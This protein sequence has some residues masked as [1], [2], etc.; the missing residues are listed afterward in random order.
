MLAGDGPKRGHR[1]ASRT[2]A[3]PSSS[4]GSMPSMSN[5]ERDPVE[6]VCPPQELSGP[7]VQVLAARDVPLGGPRAMNVRRTLPQ[8]GR[9]TIGAWCFADHYGPDDVATSGGMVV[10]NRSRYPPPYRRS[11]S[12]TVGIGQ[13]SIKVSIRAIACSWLAVVRWR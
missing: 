12:A 1:S 10:P 4:A 8:R 5:L 6:L 9:T 3:P 2:T 7:V 13:G 11:T